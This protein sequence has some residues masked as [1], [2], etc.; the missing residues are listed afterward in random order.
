M[1]IQSAKF[2]Q[3]VL[4]ELFSYNNQYQSIFYQKSDQVFIGQFV[5][6]FYRFLPLDKNVPNHMINQQNFCLKVKVLIL[7]SVC[8]F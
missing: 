7:T 6:D 4:K 2:Y 8:L 5:I 3:K 1:I